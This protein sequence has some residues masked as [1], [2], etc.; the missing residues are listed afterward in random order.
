MYMMQT[1][2]PY[3]YYVNIVNNNPYMLSYDLYKMNN[4]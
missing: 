3:R 1:D 2:R 4:Q